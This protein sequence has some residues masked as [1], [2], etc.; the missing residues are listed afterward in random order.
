MPWGLSS[1]A[2]LC[3]TVNTEVMGD[4]LS[5]AHSVLARC[6]HLPELLITSSYSSCQRLQWLPKTPHLA[7]SLSKYGLHLAFKPD[8]PLLPGYNLSSNETLLLPV[9][10]AMLLFMLIPPQFFLGHLHSITICWNPI[11][12]SK[13]LSDASYKNPLQ[14]L[15]D[16][17]DL[18]QILHTL[19][20]VR[21]DS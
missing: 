3:C 4:L 19:L 7:I 2:R 9:P 18:L 8:L 6:C 14:P 13:P 1:G 11:H 16:A 15:N 12:P 20:P 21:L 5:Q 10:A 17:Y